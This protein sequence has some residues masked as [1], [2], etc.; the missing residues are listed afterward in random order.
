M[1]VLALAG[2]TGMYLRQVRQIR[3]ARARRLPRSSPSATWSMFA[4]EVHRRL[5]LP[6]LTHTEPGFVNDVVVAAVGGTPDRRHRPPADLFIVSRASATSLGGLLFGIALFRARVLA[7]WAAALLAVSTVVRAALSRAAGLVRPADRRPRRRRAHR[8]GRLPV[9]RPAP[10]PL[11]SAGAGVDRR[12]GRRDD[13]TTHLRDPHR[14]PPRRPLVGVARRLR[15]RPATTT[16]PRRSSA[17]SPTS[18]AAR[19]ARRAA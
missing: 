9:A 15:P 3:R 4:T 5:V 12:A 1:A 7:R 16:A 8:P 14:W 17:P 10:A 11:V 18:A 19:R 2:I 13:A 6:T